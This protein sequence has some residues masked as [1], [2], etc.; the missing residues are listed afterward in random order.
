[1]L[2]TNKKRKETF[3]G[4][5]QRTFPGALRSTGPSTR[6][7]QEGLTDG[8][9]GRR[10]LQDPWR[11][12]HWRNMLRLCRLLQKMWKC[13][14]WMWYLVYKAQKYES[15]RRRIES[16]RHEQT[17]TALSVTHLWLDSG[18]Y[19]DEHHKRKEELHW[20]AVTWRR[21]QWGPQ[22][23]TSL[24]T[25]CCKLGY[26]SFEDKCCGKVGRRVLHGERKI[27]TCHRHNWWSDVEGCYE[28]ILC[29]VPL[30]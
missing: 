8:F 10:S 3:R 18:V 16:N 24:T 4:T 23:E 1:M 21:I 2:G 26:Q 20:G 22:T 25:C 17:D 13:S 19:R 6:V 15:R 28:G 7:Q 29:S 9:S 11:G 14:G 12:L 30:S 5:L 27:E